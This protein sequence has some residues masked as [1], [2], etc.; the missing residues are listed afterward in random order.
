MAIETKVKSGGLWRNI[1]TP[2][3][4]SGGV[5]RTITSIEVKSG[6]IWRK[7]FEA[8]ATV[9]SLVNMASSYTD[10]GGPTQ[11]YGVNIIFQT[12]GTLDV[13]KDIGADLFDEEQYVDP[14]SE[15]SNTWVRCTYVSGND[16][17]GGGARGVW[18]RA[19]LAVSFLMR[20]TTS[21]GTDQISGVFNFELSSDASGSPIEATKNN[22][23]VT[24]GEIF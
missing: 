11:T 16:M 20:Y 4:K 17:T 7:V 8:V 14:G 9:W 3:V 13:F 1:T 21:G 18:H 2:Q 6:G 19:N 5:W 12:D 23:T 15:S 22:V 24:V 10:L